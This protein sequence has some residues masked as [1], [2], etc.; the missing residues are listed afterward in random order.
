[1]DVQRKIIEMC[2]RIAQMLITKNRKYGNSALS[3]LRVFSKAD[4]LETIRVRM[5]DKL[6]RIKNQQGDEDEDAYMD[7]AGYLVLYMIAREGQA[8][9]PNDDGKPPKPMPTNK[10]ENHNMQD[11]LQAMVDTLQKERK[12]MLEA[13]AT[14]G[15]TMEG[16]RL[17][18]NGHVMTRSDVENMMSGRHI[19]KVQRDALAY[20]LDRL[21]E[22]PKPSGN[23]LK[24]ADGP[25]LMPGNA[26]ISPYE[27]TLKKL[28]EPKGVSLDT[29]EDNALTLLLVQA[30]ESNDEPLISAIKAEEKRRGCIKNGPDGGCGFDETSVTPTT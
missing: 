30:M 28:R 16:D 4:L 24:K 20:W 11:K 23:D 18:N 25:F 17:V 7:L 29:M 2:D 26:A 19:A 21:Y 10:R 1:M 14:I 13:L 15:V 27:A 22:K 8:G 9:V 5:D 3:Q 12:Q 6:C